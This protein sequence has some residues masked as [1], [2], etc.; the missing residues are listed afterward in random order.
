MK[1]NYHRPKTSFPINYVPSH[2]QNNNNNVL[3]QHDDS[4]EPIG[5]ITKPILEKKLISQPEI[6]FIIP[7][8]EDSIYKSVKSKKGYIT[9]FLVVLS[10]PKLSIQLIIIELILIILYRIITNMKILSLSSLLYVILSL[11]FGIL[12]RS[13]TECIT[14]K[15]MVYV[16]EN[17]IQLIVIS[18]FFRNESIDIIMY[19]YLGLFVHIKKS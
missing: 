17:F 7:P 6:P 19:F 16:L 9:D 14:N 1:N 12:I 15:K 10:Y 3:L 11:C 13:L 8:E 4:L 18:L 5:T 2:Q